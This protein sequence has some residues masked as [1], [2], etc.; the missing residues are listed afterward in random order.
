M[1]AAA[2]IGRVVL[3]ILAVLIGGALLAAGCVYRGYVRVVT[4][5]EGVKQQWGQVENQLQRRYDLIPSLV[6]TVRGVA[7][8]EQALINSVTEARKT[9][10]Q[11]GASVAQKAAAAGAVES[12]LSR[13]LMLQETYPQLRSN[14]SFL[15]LQDQIEGTENRLATERG[16]YN[17]AVGALNAY[18]RGPLGRFYAGWA[19]VEKAE[20]FKPPEEVKAVPKVDFSGLGR[21]STPAATATAPAR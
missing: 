17:D 10:F 14:E 1:M 16:R 11:P 12:V 7:T 4:M 19:G 8:Q 18:I 2:R 9:Y 15:K 3:I 5:D 21:S 13:L 6:E 20:Y